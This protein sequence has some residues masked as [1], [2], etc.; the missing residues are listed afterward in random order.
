MA[1]LSNTKDFLLSGTKDFFK[2][3]AY[4]KQD[5]RSRCDL[6]SV[7]EAHV[8][9]KTRLGYHV[10]GKIHEPLELSLVGQNGICQL[11]N[12]INSMVLEPYCDKEIYSQLKR[13]HQQFH[14]YGALIVEKLQAGDQFGAA[15][16]FKN[17]YSLSLRRIIQSLTEINKQLQD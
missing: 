6:V 4:R 7:A 5:I 15:A 9:W 12:W 8:L 13:S 16:I 3:D 14:H 10:Q 17:E 2:F 1:L 11:E